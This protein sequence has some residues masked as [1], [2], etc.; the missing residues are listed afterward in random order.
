[1]RDTSPEIEKQYLQMMMERS[2]QERLKMGFSMVNLARKQ[3]L[4]SIIRN[5]LTAGA[6]EIRKELFL[7][8][9]A[10]D[11]S[12]EDQEKILRWIGSLNKE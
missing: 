10:E 9:Y 2:G 4:A 12:P 7:R 5:N 1:M 11:F 3:A 8:F 6:E